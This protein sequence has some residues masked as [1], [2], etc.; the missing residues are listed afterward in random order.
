MQNRTT[1]AF[2]PIVAAKIAESV[3]FG[4][5]TDRQLTV[6][7]YVMLGLSNK[8]IS[9]HMTIADGTVKAHVRAIFRKLGASRRTEAVAIARR[10]GLLLENLM[11]DLNREW[12]HDGVPHSATRMTGT[13]Y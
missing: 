10:R 13:G 8:E 2:A 9:R 12:S 11:P 1:T 3:T 7:R 4:S 6:L 5:L